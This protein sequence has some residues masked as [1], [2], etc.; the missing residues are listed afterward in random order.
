MD[1]GAPIRASALRNFLSRRTASGFSQQSD[2]SRRGEYYVELRVFR[3]RELEP[4]AAES[5]RW[6]RAFVTYKAAVNDG[7][8]VFQA[9]SRV[10]SAAKEEFKGIQPL[11]YPSTSF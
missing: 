11:L 1:N 4:Y 8:P 9:V 7:S 10:V 5:T 3:T 6:K 2:P